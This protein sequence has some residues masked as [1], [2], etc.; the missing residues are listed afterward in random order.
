MAARGTKRWADENQAPSN[1]PQK[2]AGKSSELE[3]LLAV[4]GASRCAKTADWRLEDAFSFRQRVAQQVL[5]PELKEKLVGALTQEWSEMEKLEALLRPTV[6][7]DSSANDSLIRLLLHV[8]ALQS[9]IAAGLMQLLP[10]YQDETTDSG[11]FSM[12]R[13]ILSQ[14]RTVPRR[15]I[16]ELHL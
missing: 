5:L 12:I 15:P 16:F 3:E 4:A 14:F 7:S 8:E 9:E 1:R 6:G 13:R 10:D 2:R 11:G